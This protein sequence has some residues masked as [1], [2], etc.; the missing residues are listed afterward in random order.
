MFI[1]FKCLQNVIFT[2]FSAV[3]NV[4]KLIASLTKRKIENNEI[5]QMSHCKKRLP[6]TKQCLIIIILFKENV[7]QN[8]TY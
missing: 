2:H 1:I 4:T 3:I 6:Y 8:I 7:Q 5:I